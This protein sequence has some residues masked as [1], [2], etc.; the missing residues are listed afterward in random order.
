[1]ESILIPQVVMGI[2]EKR[3]PYLEYKGTPKKVD[4]LHEMMKSYHLNGLK[5]EWATRFPAFEDKI[6]VAKTLYMLPKTEV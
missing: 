4:N 1:M 6:H 2:I 3:Q 5:G